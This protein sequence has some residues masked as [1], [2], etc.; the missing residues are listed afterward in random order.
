MPETELHYRYTPK[1]AQRAF[2]V[3]LW[4]SYAAFVVMSILLGAG[5][6]LE[7]RNAELRPL[8]CFGLGVIAMLWWSWLNAYRWAGQLARRMPNPELTLRLSDT[9]IELSSRDTM[10]RLSWSAVR[11]VFRSKHVW[12]IEHRA[13]R[14]RSAV[15]VVA[16]TP[17][18]KEFI[19]QRVG[20]AGG[21]VR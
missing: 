20:S 17:E 1:M 13:T 5:C 19:V 7:L 4:D 6:A 2:V 11:C 14:S 21:L 16:L 3:S 8:A 15:P 18:A 10:S 9:G 12:V